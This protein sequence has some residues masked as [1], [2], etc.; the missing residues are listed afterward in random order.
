MRKENSVSRRLAEAGDASE[1]FVAGRHTQHTSNT[2]S[3]ETPRL[4]PHRLPYPLLLFF[5][6]VH[7]SALEKRCR[8]S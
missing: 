8:L 4:N 5:F 7:F 1:R 3:A 2:W 6:H